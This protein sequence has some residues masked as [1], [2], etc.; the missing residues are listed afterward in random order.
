MTFKL[1]DS[2]STFSRGYYVR[3]WTVGKLG[4]SVLIGVTDEPYFCC[5]RA[6]PLFAFALAKDLLK[7]RSGLSDIEYCSLI[8]ELDDL[9]TSKGDDSLDSIETIFCA[10]SSAEVKRLS[11]LSLAS[12][13]GIRSILNQNGKFLCVG[14][15]DE[16]FSPL[17]VHISRAPLVGLNILKSLKDAPQFHT[18]LELIHNG[19]EPTS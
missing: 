5:I 3:E 14:I 13:F 1:K 8:M 2:I 12:S 4:S 18:F 16:G 6:S 19:P 9:H 15:P 7:H 11:D 10:N 17:Q